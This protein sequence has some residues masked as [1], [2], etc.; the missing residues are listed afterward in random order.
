MDISNPKAL[1]LGTK[2]SSE[3]K[4]DSEQKDY[5]NKLFATYSKWVNI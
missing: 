1:S 5:M 3:L 2:I 4:L